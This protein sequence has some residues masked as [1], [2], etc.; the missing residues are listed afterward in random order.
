MN[1]LAP[2]D[3]HRA[4]HRSSLVSTHPLV[5]NNAMTL[6]LMGVVVT[7]AVLLE[8]M[9]ADG[10]RPVRAAHVVRPAADPSGR[11]AAAPA[12]DTV[13]AFAAQVAEEARAAFNVTGLSVGVVCNHSVVYA[14]GIGF[15]NRE[16]GHHAD[17]HSLYQIASNTKAFTAT[18][19][20]QLEEQKLLDLDAP[21][22]QANPAFRMIDPA[23][24]EILTP[25]DLL[26]HRTGLPGHDRLTFR[27]ANRSDLMDAVAH[28]A[29][30][31]PLR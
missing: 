20:L 13:A 24:S 31:K 27:S 12:C 19:A 30:D 18:V 5:A 28:L 14:G 10:L 11:G 1:V 26:S 25:R 21:I 3:S 9:P 8:A 2:D 15:A 4:V 7:V 29:M 23:G 6:L 16:A 22:R 17:E